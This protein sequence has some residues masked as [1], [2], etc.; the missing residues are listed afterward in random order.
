MTSTQEASLRSLWVTKS[1]ARTHE[2]RNGIER[3]PLWQTMVTDSMMYNWLEVEGWQVGIVATWR[4]LLSVF[5]TSF[6]PFQE[7]DQ[8]RMKQ[9]IQ[10]PDRRTMNNTK[11]QQHYH[12]HQHRLVPESQVKRTILH[13]QQDTLY[14]DRVV[15]QA[16][17]S[18]F[19]KNLIRSRTVST[20][21]TNGTLGKG[22][23][24]ACSMSGSFI[25]L[26]I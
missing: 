15:S 14:E 26:C 2:L 16:S 23:V 17:R 9:P 19:I 13:H 25:A 21:I 8:F 12:Q 5:L 11:H 22:D 18:G 3:G 24:G 7:M 1:D 10:Q 4:K 6:P 20:T